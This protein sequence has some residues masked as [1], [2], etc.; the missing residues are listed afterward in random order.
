M[1]IW[2]AG[3]AGFVGTRLSRV[4]RN[5]GHRVFSLSRRPSSS[6]DESLQVDLSAPSSVSLMRT[7]ARSIPPEIIINA[8]SRQPGQGSFADFARSNAVVTTYLLEA[9]SQTPPRR[10]IHLS[11]LSVYATTSLLPVSEDRPASAADAYGASKRL[12][13]QI[14]ETFSPCQVVVLRLPSLYGKGQADSFI[15]GLTRTA[16]A[17]EVLELF[18]NGELVRD[19]LFIEDAIDGIERSLDAPLTGKFHLI[20]L[21][22][23]RAIKTR[24]YA[25]T[26]V[27]VL[28]SSSE[29]R[30]VDR[31]AT[32]SDLYANIDKA[33]QLLGFRPTELRES[34]QRYADE[35]RA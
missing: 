16:I 15:D 33:R 14:V 9:I 12:S 17:N 24:E 13:E 35:L 8:A 29:I 6:A 11:S 4:L 10:F 34:L 26:L 1:N 19:T 21:G 5:H 3:G 20:N 23:G 28:G 2:I 30:C 22:S 18:S 7:L 31:P 27:D 25:E 32:Q